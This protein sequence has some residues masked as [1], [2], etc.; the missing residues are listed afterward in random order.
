MDTLKGDLR[1]MSKSEGNKIVFFVLLRNTKFKHDM[2]NILTL[3]LCRRS[4]MCPRGDDRR[5]RAAGTPG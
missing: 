3:P 2:L 4:G 1:D 5:I